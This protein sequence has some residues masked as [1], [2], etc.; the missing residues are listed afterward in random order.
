[1]STEYQFVRIFCQRISKIVLQVKGVCLKSIMV[2]VANKSVRLFNLQ[3][4]CFRNQKKP[5][6]NCTKK[7][8]RSRPENSSHNYIYFFKR[9]VLFGYQWASSVCPNLL[10]AYSPVP[11][12]NIFNTSRTAWVFLMTFLSYEKK[13]PHT[14][15]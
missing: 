5:L 9:Y 4:K 1:M 11:R 12:K 6:K 13:S 2:V 15:Q 7:Y 10:L 8:L 14:F 3:K